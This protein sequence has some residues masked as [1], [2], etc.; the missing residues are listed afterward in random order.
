MPAPPQNQKEEVF[1]VSLAGKANSTEDRERLV[2]IYGE[3]AKSFNAKSKKEFAEQKE[4]LEGQ[5]LRIVNVIDKPK[6][7][8]L[9]QYD[10]DVAVI[11]ISGPPIQKGKQTPP[12]EMT[13][14]G[15]HQAEVTRFVSQDA[16]PGEKGRVKLS[17]DDDGAVTFFG[18]KLEIDGEAVMQEQVTQ[19][20][21]LP[22]YV[23]TIST[24][25]MTAA[26]QMDRER[27]LSHLKNGNYYE[28]QRKELR[29]C[30][31]C[32]G[33]RRIPN[34]GTAKKAPDGK[35]ACPECKEVGKREWN[36]RYTVVW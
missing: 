8:Y 32:R 24:K 16:K 31:E 2:A 26:P 25:K 18:V 5:R 35:M 9:A 7:L 36:V 3:V 30:Q 29:K 23:G 33:F 22:K 13:K 21:T 4:M 1:R 20:E 28:V 19:T 6:K 17:D 11:Q 34:D 10:G 27:F 15:T 12:L 14:A